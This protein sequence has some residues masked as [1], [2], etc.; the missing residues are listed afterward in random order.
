[1]LFASLR[2]LGGTLFFLAMAA[3]VGIPAGRR[4]SALAQ[5][6]GETLL[7]LDLYRPVPDDNP[8]NAENVAL[9]RRLFHERLVSKSNRLL[10]SAAT[11]TRSAC[12]RT[13]RQAGRPL[14]G[15]ARGATD[16]P[17]QGQ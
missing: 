12:W 3:T 10:G 1:M 5:P 17:R 8:L 4:G 13:C 9:G 15:G 14:A 16:L 7:G 6:N 11:I 2:V